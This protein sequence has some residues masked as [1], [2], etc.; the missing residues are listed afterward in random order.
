MLQ[1]IYGTSESISL[2][3]ESHSSIPFVNLGGMCKT[4]TY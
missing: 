1:Y 4:S 3:K 2:R